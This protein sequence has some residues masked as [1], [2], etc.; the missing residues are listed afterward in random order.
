MATKKIHTENTNCIP[1]CAL[2]KT[3]C[4]CGLKRVNHNVHEEN[5]HGEHKLHSSVFFVQTF[6]SLWFK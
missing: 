1:P 3:L 2:C 4:L 6:E 5:T